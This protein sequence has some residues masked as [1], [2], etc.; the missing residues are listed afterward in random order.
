VTAIT[1][2]ANEVAKIDLG[3]G[4]P[5]RRSYAGIPCG[6]LLMSLPVIERPFGHKSVTLQRPTRVM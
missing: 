6:E 3:T 2:P 1:E 4:G 5:Q